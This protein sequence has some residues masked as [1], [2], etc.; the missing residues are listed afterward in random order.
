MCA[1]D[2]SLSLPNMAFWLLFAIQSIDSIAWSHEHLHSTDC[3]VNVLN[4]INYLILTKPLGDTY[5]YLCF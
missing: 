2:I 1:Y 5:C 3:V 4:Y